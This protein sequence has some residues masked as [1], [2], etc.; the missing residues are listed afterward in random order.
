MEVADETTLAVLPPM[1]DCT[2]DAVDA[3]SSAHIPLP[4]TDNG[5]EVPAVTV[6]TSDTCVRHGGIDSTPG[7]DNTR[8][9]RSCA[10]RTDRIASHHT[11]R[12]P[13]AGGP[14]AS[15][16]RHDEQAL[17][18]DEPALSHQ[19]FTP[20]QP[21]HRWS[22]SVPAAA[23]SSAVA[24]VA[25]PDLFYPFSSSSPSTS[26]SYWTLFGASAEASSFTPPHTSNLHSLSL[27]PSQGRH[28]P[29]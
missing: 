9:G 13:T 3:R 7:A 17:P 12:I 1:V 25:L 11:T 8:T 24:T 20:L 2:C 28:P 4:P 15:G 27:S 6:C 19:S 14:E 29:L 16:R 5:A 18:E 21:S 23:S 10:N 26:P 22:G